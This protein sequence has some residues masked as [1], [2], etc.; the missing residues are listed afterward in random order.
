MSKCQLAVFVLALSALSCAN[1]LPVR[2]SPVS[3]TPAPLSPAGAVVGHS[4]P[5]STGR[6]VA[7]ELTVRRC[8][9]EAC[10]AEELPL[11]YGAEIRIDGCFYDNGDV[12]VRFGSFWAAARFA[13]RVFM[14][15]SVC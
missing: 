5:P 2:Q 15:Q 8:P 7:S 4:T 9:S 3:S 1:F 11:Y 13:R 10:Q 12:W 14:E 6:V